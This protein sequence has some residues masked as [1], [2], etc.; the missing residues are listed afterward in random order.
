MH[1]TCS[2]RAFIYRT[3]LPESRKTM[4]CSAE[5]RRPLVV[6]DPELSFKPPLV[7]QREYEPDTGAGVG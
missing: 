4:L 7:K 2:S 5:L 1:R 6:A 3:V